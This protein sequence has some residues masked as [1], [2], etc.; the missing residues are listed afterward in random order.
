M[1]KITVSV[2]GSCVTRDTFN[3]NF[4]PDYKEYY[5]C[6]STAWQSSII[7]LMSKKIELENEFLEGN[8][9]D[10]HKQSL[11]NDLAKSYLTE[12]RNTPPDYILFDVYADL[13]YG[14]AKF[15]EGYVTNN[16]NNFRNT[17]AYKEKL[18][19]REM[20]MVSNKKIYLELW[21]KSF[22]DLHRFIQENI[23]NTKL[24]LNCFKLTN[25][26]LGKDGQIHL[27]DMRKYP[28]LDVENQL[29]DEIYDYLK[30]EYNITSIDL[31]TNEYFAD[32]RHPFTLTPWHYG[33]EYYLDMVDELNKISLKDTLLKI[34]KIRDV[35]NT[36][37]SAL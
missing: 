7:S 30:Q 37:C 12:I 20:R 24:I 21:K 14:V 34:Q 8:L 19:Q 32:E 9:N 1:E 18:F 13:K 28:N 6:I 22:E 33:K 27:F 25:C 2:I 11:G 15:N 35:I 26:F 10:F 16:P 31:R 29:L 5:E 23:P 17:K 36:K 3:R 4:V